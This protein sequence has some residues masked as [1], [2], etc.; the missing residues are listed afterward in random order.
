MVAIITGGASGIGKATAQEFINQGAAVVI[1]DI[2]AQAGHKTTD[3]LGPR[4]KFIACDVSVEKQVEE[5]VDFAV[6]EHGKLDVMY[7]NAGS[8]G[9]TVPPS[10]VDL[11][12]HEFDRVLGV[13]LRGAVAGIKHAARVMVPSGSGSILCTASVSGLMAGLGPHPY[14]VSK[15]AI[16]GLV[17]SAAA[18]LGQHGVRVNC[19]SPFA[20]PTKFVVDQLVGFYPGVGREGVEKMVRGLGELKGATCEVSDVAWAAVYLASDEA[21][22]VTGHNLVVDGGFTTAKRLA[23]PPPTGPIH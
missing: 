5:A 22:Y 16:P 7:N 6:A 8:S 19:I 21:K 4:A 2:D 23:F 1:A 10:I 12:L 13:N 20:V 11:D 14:T 15:F 18:E 3:E 9:P 17:K